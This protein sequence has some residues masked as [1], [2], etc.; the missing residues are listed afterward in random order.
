MSAFIGQTAHF[1]SNCTTL[2]LKP[3]LSIFGL[4]NNQKKIIPTEL[5][6]QTDSKTKATGLYS[7]EV[8]LIP[9]FAGV[10]HLKKWQIGCF[11]GI[12]GVIQAKSYAL[13]DFNRSFLGL[14]PRTDFRFSVGY[15]ESRFFSFLI[16][17]FENKSIQFNKLKYKQTHY[18]LRLSIGY[19]F[20]RKKL[21]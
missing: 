10:H 9:G 6:K 18:S 19:R 5:Q 21:I 12:G 16:G 15:S 4:N 17:D 2:F 20:E 8:G 11:L 1:N 14:A 7:I 13:E 3:T